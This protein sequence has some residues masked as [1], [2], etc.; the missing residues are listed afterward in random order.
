MTEPENRG[1]RELIAFN[2]GELVFRFRTDGARIKLG[3]EGGFKYASS[4]DGDTSHLAAVQL[5]RSHGDWNRQYLAGIGFGHVLANGFIKQINVAE[6]PDVVI[7]EP[8]QV[9]GFNSERKA[10]GLYV[11]YPKRGDIQPDL[12]IDVP[13]P[14]LVM[15]EVLS[16]ARHISM[17][18]KFD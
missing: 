14:L 9:P 5:D 11:N 1:E 12:E 7:G 3:R 18:I 2:D 8:W 17:G 13:S 6:I 15:R 10:T 4:F 16:H